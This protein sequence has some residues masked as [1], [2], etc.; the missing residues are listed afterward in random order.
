MPAEGLTVMPNRTLVGVTS[1]VGTDAF[2]GH[3]FG[4]KER[5]P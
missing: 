4:V 3:A 5:Q 2:H 1:D